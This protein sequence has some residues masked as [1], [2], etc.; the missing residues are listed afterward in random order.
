MDYLKLHL[1]MASIRTCRRASNSD[2]DQDQIHDNPQDLQYDADHPTDFARLRKSLTG[3]VHS[4]CRHLF[5][6]FAAHHPRDDTADETAEDAKYPKDQDQSAAV[7][8]ERGRHS[9]S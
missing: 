3:R 9:C 6:I 4:P 1:P 5:Q 8:L 7:G 2:R